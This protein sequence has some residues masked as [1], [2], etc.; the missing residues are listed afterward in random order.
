MKRPTIFICI[1]FILSIT[2]VASAQVE[3][4]GTVT[5]IVDGKTVVLQLANGP[6]KVSLQFIDVPELDQP[7]YQIVVEHLGILVRGKSAD[8]RLAGM[9]AN[10]ARG[11]LI[12]DGIDISQQMLRDGAA[13]LMPKE[14]SGQS[15]SDFAAYK[16]T[17]DQA[18]SERIGVWSISGLKPAWEFR[19]EQQEKIRQQQE[20]ARSS[21]AVRSGLGPF[22]S[23]AK[24][25]EFNN[26][27]FAAFDKDSW[28]NFIT[29]RGVETRGVHSYD[30]PS[31]RFQAFYTSNALIELGAGPARQKVDCRAVYASL[32]PPDGTRQD[33]Y[34]LLFIAL[35]D[36]YNFSRR[37][38]HL[39][40]IAD[41]TT[42]SASLHHG[43]RG[44]AV[45]GA[46]EI[47]YYWLSRASFKKIAEANSVQVRIDNLTGRMSRDTQDLIRQ[48]IAGN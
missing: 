10:A 14:I 12:V 43:L 25:G 22:Q 27:K 7:L 36:D 11:Q 5:E 16:L 48:L 45:I 37:A 33:I 13:W 39:N 26:A 6:M 19:A 9:A 32:R 44:K 29:G 42:I 1:A 35:S 41:G 23:N 15:A 31:G 38:S 18:R 46:G 17:E 47:L 28:F 34:V 3:L 2:H 8:F 30:D 20:A 40:V 4:R 24:P 21:R